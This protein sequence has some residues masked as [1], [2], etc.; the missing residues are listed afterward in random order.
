MSRSLSK[1]EILRLF[2]EKIID[3]FDALIEQFPNEGDFI[4]LRILVEDAPVEATIKNFHKVVVPH[5]E[6]ITSKNEKFFLEKCPEILKNIPGSSI[7]TNKIEHFKRVWLSPILTDED[8]EQMWKWF[9]LF[10]NLSQQYQKYT[11]V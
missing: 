8:K 4:M 7:E 10:L 9:N 11:S 3:F 2:R 5:S 6:M 1:I